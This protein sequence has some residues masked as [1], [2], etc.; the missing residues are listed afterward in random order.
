MRP[1]FLIFLPPAGK[2][3]LARWCPS[4]HKGWT[5][6][7]TLQLPA[8]GTWPPPSPW[9]LQCLRFQHGSCFVLHLCLSPGSTATA[10]LC[11]CIQS[12]AASNAL[13]NM[14]V[15]VGGRAP[16][17]SVW[18][19]F[20][21]SVTSK[22]TGFSMLLRACAYWRCTGVYMHFSLVSKCTFPS[23]TLIN[24]TPQGC[25]GAGANRLQH[26]KCATLQANTVPSRYQ[27]QNEMHVHNVSLLTLV[28]LILFKCKYIYF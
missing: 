16:S 2:R 1:D 5:S 21:P 11:H 3:L 24:P 12:Q 22:L 18:G 13:I 15:A 10:S 19:A 6:P 17:R 8:N 26:H 7:Q 25:D 28:L 4:R 23:T 14:L 20:P 9:R 27:S